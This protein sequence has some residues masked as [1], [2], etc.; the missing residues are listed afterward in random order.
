MIF[1]FD[2]VFFLSFIAI[3]LKFFCRTES[4]EQRNYWVGHKNGEKTPFLWP[5][6][7]F[8][9][10][11]TQCD[12]LVLRKWQKMPEIETWSKLIITLPR[13]LDWGTLNRPSKCPKFYTTKISG[14][15]EFTLKRA[16]L[17][18]LFKSDKVLYY[19]NNTQFE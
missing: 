8:F 6:N 2:Y 13:K 18:S 3:F 16:E 7:N 12:E 5:T 11:L 4:V 10:A 17:L 1:N 19:L 15:K 14:E 9:L